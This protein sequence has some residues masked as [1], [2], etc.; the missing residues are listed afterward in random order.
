[1]NKIKHFFIHHKKL[2]IF[3][4][5]SLFMV[6]FFTQFA[7]IRMGNVP[8]MV[9]DRWQM[10]RV[11]RIEVETCY[12]TTIIN[13]RQLIADF[14]A[15]TIVANDW[16]QC[17]AGFSS[18]TVFFRLYRNDNLVRDMEF[19]FKHY[20]T[21]VYFPSRNHFFFSAG[22]AGVRYSLNEFGGVVI[23]PRELKGRIH[24]YLLSNDNRLFHSDPWWLSDL[25]SY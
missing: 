20:Q 12:G 21:R 24:Q 4:G 11:N 17:A 19:E 1:M 25:S 23:L 7:A 9:L 6:I 8:S 3:I 14:V 10:E 16:A 18:G 15:A 13:E 2:T 22:M 5:I